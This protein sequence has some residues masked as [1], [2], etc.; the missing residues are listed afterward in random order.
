[1]LIN[2]FG[3]YVMKS[4]LIFMLIC[5]IPMLMIAAQPASQ[6]TTNESKI[7]YDLHP[8]HDK[9][10]VYA[11]QLDSSEEEQDEEEQE[12]EDLEKY[13]KSKHKTE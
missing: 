2:L 8:E 6:S 11:I 4:K 9:T 12:L 13:E 10:D 7:P 1:M 3:E 5:S